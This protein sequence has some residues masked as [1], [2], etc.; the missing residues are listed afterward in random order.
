MEI[1]KFIF[2]NFWIWLGFTFIFFNICYGMYKLIVKTLRHR[3]LMKHGYPPEYC[4]VDGEF[5]NEIEDE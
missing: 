4:N 2:S 1:L 3:V 5:K